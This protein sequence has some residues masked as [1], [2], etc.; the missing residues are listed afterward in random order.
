MI[1]HRRFSTVWKHEKFTLTENIF[2]EIISLVTTSSVKML[3]SRTFCQ[4]C[5]RVNFC[6]FHTVLST[7]IL[8]FIVTDYLETADSNETIFL[9]T[10]LVTFLTRDMVNTGKVKNLL[11][12]NALFGCLN[13]SLLNKI[14]A[15]QKKTLVYFWS[16]YIQNVF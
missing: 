8:W 1:F 11:R 15:S 7:N 12:K 10:F 13:Y 3:L 9:A 4:K 5:V 6:N 2:R 14:L 16:S